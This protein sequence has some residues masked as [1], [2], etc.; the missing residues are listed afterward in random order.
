MDRLKYCEIQ[1]PKINRWRTANTKEM[2]K[3]SLIPAKSK[4]V[5]IGSNYILLNQREETLML[6]F[7]AQGCR[8]QISSLMSQET[9]YVH[10]L[11]QDI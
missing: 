8:G 10:N 11:G 6:V 4:W 1:T 9:Q 3:W 5:E 7:T 2:L